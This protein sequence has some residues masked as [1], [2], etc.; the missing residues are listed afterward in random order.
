MTSGGM[1]A[2][3][4]RPPIRRGPCP[5]TIGSNLYKQLVVFRPYFLR[6]QI[7]QETG[8]CKKIGGNAAYYKIT[9]AKAISFKTVIN[10]NFN[11]PWIYWGHLNTLIKGENAQ[12]HNTLHVENNELTSDPNK[13]AKAFNLAF[14]N[15]EHK[16]IDVSLQGTS[17]IQKLRSFASNMKPSGKLSNIPPIRSCFV[18]E[19]VNWRLRLKPQ[20]L[21]KLRLDSW[22]FVFKKIADS[23]WN[24]HFSGYLEDCSRNPDLQ[25]R[26]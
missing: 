14:V 19:Q 22:K 21:T 26:W 8:D 23:L 13:V 25:I 12:Q 15:I 10:D 17:D 5:S 3:C 24:C 7:D 2:R 11:N 20:V 16:Y 18:K 1:A 9:S 4:I 6:L